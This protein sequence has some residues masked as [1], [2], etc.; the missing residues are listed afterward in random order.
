[1]RFSTND[2]LKI[3]YHEYL[4]PHDIAHKHVEKYSFQAN[5]N[6]NW[7]CDIGLKIEIIKNNLVDLQPGQ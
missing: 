5:M 3:R 1:M 4:A 7:T 2:N 6:V